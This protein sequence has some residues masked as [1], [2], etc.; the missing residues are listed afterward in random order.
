MNTKQLYVLKKLI[1]DFEEQLKEN[2]DNFDYLEIQN[3]ESDVFD[4]VEFTKGGSKIET[5]GIPTTIRLS[6]EIE[7]VTDSKDLDSGVSHRTIKTN[8]YEIDDDYSPK[9]QLLYT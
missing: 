5:S 1:T 3:L 4:T 7:L 9:N 2:I 8:F 6:M